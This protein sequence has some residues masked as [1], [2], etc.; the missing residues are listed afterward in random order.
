MYVC[1]YFSDFYCLELS[2]FPLLILHYYFVIF[3]RESIVVFMHSN[4]NRYNRWQ[5]HVH[6]GIITMLIMIIT[7][8]WWYYTMACSFF[9]VETLFF[10]AGKKNSLKPVH[11]QCLLF[12]CI[13]SKLFCAFHANWCCCVFF[14]LWNIFVMVLT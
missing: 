6:V 9:V 11:S 7:E 13:F 2:S 4:I 8:I 12:T 10:V 5:M 14:A 1:V 3:K